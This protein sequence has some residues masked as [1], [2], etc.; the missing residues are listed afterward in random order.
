MHSLRSILL[1]AH[2][3]LFFSLLHSMEP[4]SLD[5]IPDDVIQ[6]SIAPYLK[7]DAE[8]AFRTTSHRGL[9]LITGFRVTCEQARKRDLREEKK[10]K[11]ALM[12]GLKRA[13]KIDFPLCLYNFDHSIG[14]IA[15]QDTKHSLYYQHE[16]FY[17]N[18][19]EKVNTAMAMCS[20][21]QNTGGCAFLASGKV[22]M[23]NADD[24]SVRLVYVYP[25]NKDYPN[26]SKLTTDADRN[27]FYEN[28]AYTIF[29]TNVVD[30]NGPESRNMPLSLPFFSG[31]RE[32]MAFVPGY[33]YPVQLCTFMLDTLEIDHQLK[34]IKC[35]ILSN[36]NTDPIKFSKLSAYPLLMC[37]LVETCYSHTD[38]VE[39]YFDPKRLT[40]KGKSLTEL[41]RKMTEVI[42]QGSVPS[43]K[44]LDDA[45]VLPWA[46]L[47]YMYG[48][49]NKA[50]DYCKL[51]VE[52]KAIKKVLHQNNIDYSLDLDDVFQQCSD[53]GTRLPL[54]QFLDGS[55]HYVIYG[56]AGETC[57]SVNRI[58]NFYKHV[59][60]EN[61]SGIRYSHCVN[62]DPIVISSQ[63]ECSYVALK[64][65][66][67]RCR[68]HQVAL[69]LTN[70]DKQQ[71]I[72]LYNTGIHIPSVHL[73]DISLQG[74]SWWTNSVE[75]ID[76]DPE[77]SDTLVLTT[78]PFTDF[79]RRKK[80][81]TIEIKGVSHLLSINQVTGLPQKKMSK[82]MRLDME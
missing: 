82:L 37:A 44:E 62:R 4:A 41:Q 70:P 79:L 53:T 63:E 43:R 14:K 18:G 20:Y 5:L 74:S 16:P 33:Y 73:G 57:Y 21:N 15:K 27:A 50:V 80:R 81:K 29:N 77:E 75:F 54:Q 8:N 60:I 13:W 19:F 42:I 46:I 26:F 66:D 17:E 10:Q 76:F 39:A 36:D 69:L 11:I 23:G 52:R 67:D 47:C 38:G 25:K 9:C 78:E 58:N 40:L 3:G 45:M 35:S 49:I 72:S 34:S 68:R 51:Y 2:V 6:N 59:R 61:F 1:L 28:V 12:K 24:F 32:V 30:Q 22:L 48:N 65:L 56:G 55:A 7:Y 31:S 71:K 64:A